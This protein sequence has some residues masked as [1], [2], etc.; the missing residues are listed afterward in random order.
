[1][2]F[3]EEQKRVRRERS[4]K[5]M[6][7]HGKAK[8]QRWAKDNPE[9]AKAQNRAKFKRHYTKHQDDSDFLH[10]NCEKQ[11][12][13]A[14]SKRE[15][16]RAV[17]LYY[18]CQNPQCPCHNEQFMPEDLDFHHLSD[19]MFSLGSNFKSP[20]PVLA[21]EINKCVVL[22]SICHRRLHVGRFSA[23]GLRRC[24]VDEELQVINDPSQVHLQS[25]PALGS[26]C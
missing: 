8:K 13:H 3:T 12:R 16:I 14:K 10:R 7:E 11:R 2:Q 4:R 1:M 22:C 15:S 20:K 19:N 23:E 18:G 24:H 5:W 21:A 17:A 9:Q 6:A 26:P 25:S